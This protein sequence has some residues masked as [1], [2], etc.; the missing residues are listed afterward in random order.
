[1]VEVSVDKQK[2]FEVFE[3]LITSHYDRLGIFCFNHIVP[4]IKYS[5]GFDVGSKEHSLFLFYSVALDALRESN[6]VYAAG[7][8]IAMN[9]DN[10]GVINLGIGGIEAVMKRVLDN[11]IGNPANIL[12]E[13]ALNLSE[14]CKGDPRVFFKDLKSYDEAKSALLKFHGIGNGKANL[15]IKNFVRFGYFKPRNIFDVPI[16]VDRHAIRISIGNGVVGFDE[17]GN[18]HVSNVVLKLDDLYREILN[19]GHFDPILVDDLKWIVG[20]QLCTKKSFRICKE[21][22][23]LNC[24][25]MVRTN[26]SNSY[27]V[28]PSDVRLGNGNVNSKQLSL[29]GGDFK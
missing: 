27:V 29:F 6:S 17:G 28:I 11:G 19:E 16:K 3:K 14:T 7:R 23:P 22:C 4:E 21:Y 2:G 15:M 1:M 24:S 25:M 5:N 18:I 13:T 12:L 20:S 8:Y 9:Y 26:K 10:S